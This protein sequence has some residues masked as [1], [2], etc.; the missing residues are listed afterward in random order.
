MIDNPTPTPNSLLPSK[1]KDKPL[2]TTV[3]SHQSGYQPP[4]VLVKKIPP[5]VTDSELAKVFA[6]FGDV[7][8]VNI[9]QPKLYAYVEFAVVSLL[10]RISL[11]PRSVLTSLLVLH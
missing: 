5:S 11:R 8:C 7:Q 2:D 3:A 9:L 10:I 6:A 1:D 4:I